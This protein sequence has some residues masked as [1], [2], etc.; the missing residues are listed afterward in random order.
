MARITVSNTDYEST[1]NSEYHSE[2]QSQSQSQNQSSTKKVL[3]SKLRDQ[4]LAGLMGYMTDEEI[5]AY[6]ENLLQPQRDAEKE[7]A[8]QKYDTSRLS[9]EQEIESLAAELTRS[10]EE[11]R[12][13]YTQSAADVQTA[14]LARGMGR[15]SYMLD[16]LANEGDRL[17]RV[18]RELTQENERR[19]EQVRD[20]LALSAQHNAQTQG[21]LEADYAKNLAAKVQELKES[22]RKEYNQNY[23]AAVNASM[24]S[25]TAGSSSTT[26]SSTSTTT[27]QSH[28]QG[29]SSTVTKSYSTG[30]GSSK[31]SSQVDAVSGAAQSVKYR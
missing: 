28:T 9:G 20:Q 2:S 23:L 5:Y 15:S 17:A 1:T 25:S 10:I 18:V 3:D 4:I 7:A 6:A 13:S 26:G 8:Q 21:R 27:G 29:S 22:Q 30:G 19:N 16:T 14:A 24:G 11:Q 31:S 12:R